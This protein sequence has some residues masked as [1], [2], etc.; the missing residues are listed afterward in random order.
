MFPWS[1]FHSSSNPTF[2]LPLDS[3]LR[4]SRVFLPYFTLSVHSCRVW[5]PNISPDLRPL[6]YAESV[7]LWSASFFHSLLPWSP[8]Q[9]LSSLSLFSVVHLWLLC[10]SWMIHYL[11]SGQPS[12]F[13]LQHL[14]VLN[15]HNMAKGN[16]PQSYC[17]WFHPHGLKLTL[18]LQKDR[19]PL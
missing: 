19:S 4:N 16:L 6:P 7:C 12:T 17:P 3:W 13:L 5:F 10:V 18:L 11:F 1:T 14:K 9:S 2:L 8:F 15:P